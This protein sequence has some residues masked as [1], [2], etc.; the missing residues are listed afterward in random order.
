MFFQKNSIFFLFLF[1]C[2]F[3]NSYF[4]YFLFLFNFFL[5]IFC[6]IATFHR[7]F[8]MLEEVGHFF[9]LFYFF[10]MIIRINFLKINV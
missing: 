2:I 5:I 10:P 7:D 8:C 1:H 4:S 6:L 3:H 9:C